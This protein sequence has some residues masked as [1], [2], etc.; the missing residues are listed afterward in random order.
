MIS[1]LVKQH[2]LDRYGS[3]ISAADL[4]RLMGAFHAGE[5]HVFIQG[6]Q[7]SLLYVAYL[8]DEYG[9]VNIE[10][11]G[12]VAVGDTPLSY[13]LLLFIREFDE[14][15]GE[16]ALKRAY[17]SRYETLH[18]YVTLGPAKAK[19]FLE[20]GKRVDE[21]VARIEEGKRS[22]ATSSTPKLTFVIEESRGSF[23][24][25]LRVGFT[26]QYLNRRVG[27]FI[28]DYYEGLSQLIQKEYVI[29][30]KHCFS[31]AV[32]AGL[33]FLYNVAAADHYSS[34]SSPVY[35]GLD[36]FLEFLSLLQGETVDF[37]GLPRLVSE[38]VPVEMEIGAS[39]GLVSS[40]PLDTKKL[41][42][43]SDMACRIGDERIEL[44]RFASKAAADLFSFY[45]D[46]REMDSSFLNELVA[47]RVLP[48]MNENEVKISSDFEKRYPVI[49]PRIEFYIG[50]EDPKGLSYD[51][52]L[53][54]GGEQVDEKRFAS[55]NED[56]KR[57]YAAF[58]DQIDAL[59]FRL[60]GKDPTDEAVV[61]FLKADLTQLESCAAI[62]VSEELQATRLVKTP[63]MGL[64]A[65]S[66]EDWFHVD[67]YA[68]GYEEDELLAIFNAY[69]RKKKF[70]R[71][72]NR[73]VVID[74]DD[75]RM[76]VLLENFSTS[77]I[78][79]D[80]PL[81]QALKLPAVTGEQ[82]AEVRDLIGKVENYARLDLPDL[83]REISAF[84]RPYQLNGIRFL[85]NLYNLR[86]SGILSDDMGLGKTLQ[87]FG[88]FAMAKTDK[89]MLVVCPKSLI[90]NWLQERDKWY[91]ALSAE[92]LVGTPSERK[93]I[94]A[95]MAKRGKAVYFVSYDTLRN[96]LS[97]IKD[98]DFSLLLLDEG[99]YI[100][101]AA[102]MKTKA[103]KELKAESRFVL[104][105]TPVQNSLADLWSIFDFLLPGYF[106]PLKKFREI[107]GGLD[108]SSE[109]ARR[110]LLAKIKP[111]LLGRKKKD[112][113]KELPEKEN[114]S[115]ALAMNEEQR[116]VYD[117]Y[118][119][120][121]R[122]ALANKDSKVQL[123]AMIT[124]LRQICVTPSLFL[125][126]AFESGK[127]DYLISSIAAL[128]DAGRRAIV[129]SSFV[130]ALD[131]IAARCKEAGLTYETIKGDTSAK[132]RLIIAERFNKPDSSIDLMLVSLKAGGTGL[133]LIGA[134]TVFHLDPWWNL[135]AE[136]Q[137]EDRA[138]RIGQTNKVTVFK[139]VAKNTI[140]DR[141][142]SLQERKG[143]LI[144]LTDEASLEKALTDED[145]RFLLS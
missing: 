54:L 14:H 56:C 120:K 127:I 34:G 62:F 136:R 67:L 29:L 97:H 46:Y 95:R 114:I 20:A 70:V 52:K 23:L 77:E 121:A 16:E 11:N 82:S 98:I 110:R 101:N 13:A 39:G 28:R 66:G 84:A 3:N 9:Q 96:D 92:I 21:L 10:M 61:N 106:P 51:T 134:D 68:S 81:Y 55:H 131:I 73:F 27:C 25:S 50:L 74:E 86:L 123:I 112:V 18:T 143:L 132:V 125:E 31:R 6:N 2:V 32:E 12:N 78:G 59:G 57:R 91:P 102:A 118:L 48:I 17:G 53:Y 130:S 8:E 79:V 76:K 89:P 133:N 15:S 69:T 87:S 141:I 36:N 5:V 22:V 26:K 109:E 44:H 64:R 139:L 37:G 41:Y 45:R 43:G 111:F 71:L 38:I 116:K 19:L 104:T 72:K 140:E 4:E 119:A 94:Y 47:K 85:S 40:L 124:R 1:R 142:L 88:L 99:Q 117:A 122:D 105:G 33:Q 24:V 108:L 83:P 7:D 135:A 80:I 145:Y 58:I 65:S 115:V 42:L 107:Y 113:L 93:A 63:E 103:V 126:G 144:D 128:K 35:L 75:E 138:H 129:F 90:Y 100:S 49:R 137:A 60:Q 30:P